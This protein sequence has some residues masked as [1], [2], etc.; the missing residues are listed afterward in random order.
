LRETS[1]ETVADLSF[2]LPEDGASLRALVQALL[3]ERQQQQRQAEDQQRHIEEQQDHLAEQQRR[4]EEQ[5]RLLAEQ[6]RLAEEQR[7]KAVQLPAELLRLQVELERYK[8]WYYGPRADR[9]RSANELAQLL[10]NFAVE[11]DQK[12]LPADNREPQTEPDKE[13][14]RVQR[15]KG[16]RDLARFENLPVTTQFY[17]LSAAERACPGCGQERQEIG[18]EERPLRTPPACAQKVCLRA[19]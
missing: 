19:L 18:S 15:R 12:P 17:E 8:E 5:Q 9:L 2:P 13:L 1:S 4:A 16:R 14:R 11:W 6:Q 10:L 3:A 7:Q